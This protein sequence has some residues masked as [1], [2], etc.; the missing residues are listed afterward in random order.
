MRVLSAMLQS[1]PLSERP[2]SLPSLVSSAIKAPRSSASIGQA[3]PVQ[4]ETPAW[5]ADP[6]PVTYRKPPAKPPRKSLLSRLSS[7]AERSFGTTPKKSFRER[8]TSAKI[9]QKIVEALAPSNL[10]KDG[11]KGSDSTLTGVGTAEAHASEPRLPLSTDRGS[12]FRAFLSDFG[13]QS[14][15]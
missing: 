13:S 10:S 12:A 6:Q 7:I 11:D 4:V 15:R 5:L 8:P 3:E 1:T 2:P 14:N 9:E